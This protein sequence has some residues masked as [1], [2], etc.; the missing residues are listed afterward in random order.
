M[1]PRQP[2]QTGVVPN[3]DGCR[4]RRK[5][6]RSA[7]PH[8]SLP[9]LRRRAPG[10]GGRIVP[11]LLRA[12]GARVFRDVVD[13][14]GDRGGTSLALALRCAAPRR[15]AGRAAARARLHAA[16]R[17]ASPRRSARHRRAVAQARHGQPNPLLQGPRRR[18]RRGEGAGAGLDHTRLLVDRQPRRRGRRPRCRR[19]TRGRGLLP[20]RPRTGE[21]RRR[22]RLRADDLR[23]GR[24]LRPLCATL[25]RAL[26]RAAVGLRQRQPAH[27]LRRGVEDARL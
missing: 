25:R 20:G 17:R 27:V 18:D 12:A 26:V 5:E 6:Q 16:R 1:K 7:R 22:R 21:A 9:R 4:A 10:R 19:G 15:P 11:P 2:A 8:P 24:Q 14:R 3:P 23:R 13:P